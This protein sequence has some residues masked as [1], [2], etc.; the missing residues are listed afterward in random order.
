MCR[1]R[2]LRTA[3]PDRRAEA[4]TLR[5]GHYGGTFRQPNCRTSHSNRTG[6][7]LAVCS[8]SAARRFSAKQHV[9]IQ[10]AACNLNNCE[11]LTNWKQKF[12][13]PAEVLGC[14]L[15]TGQRA[16][17]SGCRNGQRLPWLL[18]CAAHAAIWQPVLSSHSL[19]EL[20][21][22]SDVSAPNCL[23]VRT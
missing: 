18:Q 7:F 4:S 15:P 5:C 1:A 3:H 11:F 23:T 19:K 20:N 16:T 9:T 13:T 2:S 21:E 10:S 22:H 17:L 6:F 14:S 12:G 8:L